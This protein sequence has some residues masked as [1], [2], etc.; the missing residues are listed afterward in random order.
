MRK[1]I[2]NEQNCH[3]ERYYFCDEDH[4]VAHQFAWIEFPH[5]IQRCPDKNVRIEQFLLVNFR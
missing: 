5:R 3:A 2:A 4:G 1:P